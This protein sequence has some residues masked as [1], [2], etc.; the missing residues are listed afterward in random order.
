MVRLSNTSMNLGGPGWFNDVFDVQVF[1][2]T[3]KRSV[4]S[5]GDDEDSVEV[6]QCLLFRVWLFGPFSR[7]FVV[8]ARFPLEGVC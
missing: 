1:F 3:D 6:R 4:P 7:G 8:L 5:G 2:N